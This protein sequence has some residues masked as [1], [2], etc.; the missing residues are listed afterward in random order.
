MVQQIKNIILFVLC[1][2]I[3]HFHWH[4]FCSFQDSIGIWIYLSNCFVIDYCQLSVLLCI[5][6]I[7]EMYSR[8]YDPVSGKLLR[9]NHYL[10]TSQ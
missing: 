9:S 2:Y 1:I 10:L 7:L 8:Y 3:V 5:I 4:S 6:L